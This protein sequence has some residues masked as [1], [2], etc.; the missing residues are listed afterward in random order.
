[1]QNVCDLSNNIFSPKI[2]KIIDK[3]SDI[4]LAQKTELFW[5]KK[6]TLFW[7]KKHVKRERF[8]Q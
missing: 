5:P 6:L 7:P 4:F 1:M 3:K 8:K 2:K